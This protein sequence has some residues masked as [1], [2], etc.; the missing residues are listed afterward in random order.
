MV[1]GI[2]IFWISVLYKFL[3]ELIVYA[4][5][6]YGDTDIYLLNRDSPDD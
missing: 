3:H 4:S 2:D 6:K 5:R 1:A